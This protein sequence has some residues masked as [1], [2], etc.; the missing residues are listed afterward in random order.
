LISAIIHLQSLQKLH[1]LVIKPC[2]LN[3]LAPHQFQ[4][5]GTL[6]QG[7]QHMSPLISMPYLLFS[8][9]NGP[10]TVH[11][12]NDTGLEIAHKGSS[13]LLTTLKPLT[14]TNV[15]NVPEIIKNLLSVSQLTLDND[16]LIEFSSN[17]Y[18]I[19]DKQTNQILLHGTLNNGLYKILSPQHQQ[20]YQV[21]QSSADIWHYRLGHCSFQVQNK[22]MKE[23]LIS[24]QLS[25]VHSSCSS[26]FKA[27]AHKLPFLPS[28]TTTTKLLEVIHSYLWGPAPIVT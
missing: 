4:H 22:L 6:I 10:E 12:G 3:Q 16:I 18:F 7:Q 26:Y 23:K 20:A 15:L 8:P 21:S 5:P 27:K 24:T 19:K 28:T 11:I 1:F 17:S 25:P 9:Y 14:L 2:L 13:L